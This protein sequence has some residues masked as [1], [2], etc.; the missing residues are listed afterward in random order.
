MYN[1]SNRNNSNSNS[2]RRPAPGCTSANGS[3]PSGSN[4]GGSS[5]DDI[6]NSRVGNSGGCSDTSGSSGGSDSDSGSCGGE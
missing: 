5:Y 3:R 1:S 6:F 2:N 4:S